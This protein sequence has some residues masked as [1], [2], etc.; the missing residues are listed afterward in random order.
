MD[1]TTGY[2]LD[3]AKQQWLA[4]RSDAS[5]LRTQL[6]MARGRI[7]RYEE[8][9]KEIEDLE[10]HEIERARRIAAEITAE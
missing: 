3:K 6:Q 4:E 7:K 1:H 8:F 5:H 9:L 2:Y 10:P